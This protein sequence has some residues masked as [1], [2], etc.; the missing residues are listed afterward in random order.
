[1]SRPSDAANHF[2]VSSD[3]QY[4]SLS[5]TGKIRAEPTTLQDGQVL[6]IESVVASFD[7]Q[8]CFSRAAPLSSLPPC[9]YSMYIN[10]STRSIPKVLIH[11]SP[12]ETVAIC[13][14]GVILN[15]MVQEEAK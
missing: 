3:F 1:M 5:Y 2:T 6:E 4:N 7:G 10:Q 12:T 9:I 8:P 14:G 15:K 11:K 13:F